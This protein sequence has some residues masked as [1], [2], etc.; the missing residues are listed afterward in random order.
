MHALTIVLV[1][2]HSR[3]RTAY[4]VSY[5]RYLVL[6]WAFMSLPKKKSHWIWT[7]HST[8]RIGTKCANIIDNS[9]TFV[10]VLPRVWNRMNFWGSY[11]KYIIFTCILVPYDEYYYILA[12]KITELGWQLAIHILVQSAW[13]CYFMA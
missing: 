1:G 5:R 10:Y 4:R 3:F 9:L 6:R 11:Y 8:R 13:Y 12:N 2:L 7:F